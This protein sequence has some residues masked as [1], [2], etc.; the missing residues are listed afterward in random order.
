MST[1]EDFVSG[2]LAADETVIVIATPVHV[3]LLETLLTARGIDLE[4]VRGRDHYI[5][6]DAE[7]ILSTFVENGWP[8]EERFKKTI[9]EILVRARKSGRRVRA[10]G[11]M[12][13]LL[14]AQGHKGATV[15]LE[16]LWHM[17]CQSEQFSLYCAYP[18][19]GLPQDASAAIDA[20]CAAHT[21]VISPEGRIPSTA[22]W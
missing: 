13:A 2:G 17:Y 14:W 21:R 18:K 5:V 16:H 15:R 7:E 6:C 1:L 8:N 20:I 3:R 9:S 19:T 22:G 10:F 11:E 4:A 12:V